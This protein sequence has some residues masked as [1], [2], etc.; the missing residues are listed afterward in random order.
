VVDPGAGLN[1]VANIGHFRASTERKD[2]H[3]W[4]RCLR[5]TVTLTSSGTTATLTTSGADHGLGDI[6]DGNGGCGLYLQIVSATDARYN[7]IYPVLSVSGSTV[8]RFTTAIGNLNNAT[9][10]LQTPWDG[11]TE[12]TTGYPGMDQAGHGRSDYL[13]GAYDIPLNLVTWPNQLLE[14]AYAWNNT[15][16][17]GVASAQDSPMVIGNA[18]SPTTLV[19][20]RDFYNTTPPNFNTPS[21]YTPLVYPHPLVTAGVV[22]GGGA[23]PTGRHTHLV[24]ARKRR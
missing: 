14:P 19:E 1:R 5:H 15:I 22:V 13:G 9:G 24:H 20:G 3:Y 23:P 11:N 12:A 7:G 4:G 17:L 10:T 18:G 21:G 8:A 6:G 2:W 16:Q